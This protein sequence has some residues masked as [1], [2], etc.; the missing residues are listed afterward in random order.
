MRTL[1]NHKDGAISFRAEGVTVEADSHITVDVIIGG[2]DNILRQIVVTIA[3][4]A[5]S[6]PSLP[7]LRRM[8]VRTAAF[9]ANCVRMGCRGGSQG[10]EVIEQGSEGG[11]RAY[12]QGLLGF[13]QGF[14]GIVG[15]LHLIVDFR[16][17]LH[18]HGLDFLRGGKGVHQ[19]LNPFGGLAVRA[20]LADIGAGLLRGG[21]CVAA[22][23]VVGMGADQLPGHALAFHRADVAA[24]NPLHGFHIAAALGMGE[25][26]CCIGDAVAAVPLH[27]LHIAAGAVMG[28]DAIGHGLI[29]VFRV[30]M[31][32]GTSRARRGVAAL[33]GVGGVVGAKALRFLRERE[34]RDV[35]QKQHRRHQ[36]A[37][38]PFPGLMVHIASSYVP[39]V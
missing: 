29:A 6:I 14:V 12:N 27:G 8:V 35:S 16:L 26:A 23:T 22:G 31:G 39:R 33:V 21:G 37:K 11:L 30:F 20:S 4:I 28:M 32:A 18:G 13:G 15:R 17:I 19:G 36:T 7:G 3:N 1:V 9:A 10:V 38:R 34:N 24:G 25:D 5:L 2:S